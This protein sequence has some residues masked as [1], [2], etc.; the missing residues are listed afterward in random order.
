MPSTC[1]AV[2]APNHLLLLSK[3]AAA[4]QALSEACSPAPPLPQ[5]FTA[6]ADPQRLLRPT[7]AT[8]RRQDAA[9]EEQPG[10]RGERGF[11][12]HV[13]RL[14]TPSWCAGLKGRQ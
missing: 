7:S 9:R 6:E 8:Q 11:I 12:L 13:P 4:R 5:D 10:S 3:L 1:C 14:A 2:S